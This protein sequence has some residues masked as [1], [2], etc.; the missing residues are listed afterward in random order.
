MYLWCEGRERERKERGK[1]EERERKERKREEREK[2]RER[3]SE[4]VR[5]SEREN[6]TKDD[7][8]W[9]PGFLA[10]VL[11]FVLKLGTF[12]YLLPSTCS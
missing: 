11:Q 10:Q 3:E 4:Q 8:F 12:N 6:T 1:R 5:A 9:I 7:D 2:E